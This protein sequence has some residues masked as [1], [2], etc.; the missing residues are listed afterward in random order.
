MRKGPG[1]MK[2]EYNGHRPIWDKYNVYYLFDQDEL[3]YVGMTIDP[4]RRLSRH[5]KDKV[6]TR[7]VIS[8]VGLSKVD[9]QKYELGLIGLLKPRDN[10]LGNR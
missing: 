1:E 4:S 8:Q 7:M 5:K 10:V 2:V 6:F 9:A 3:T